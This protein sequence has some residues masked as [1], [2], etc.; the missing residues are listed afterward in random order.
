M[1][2]ES[3]QAECRDCRLPYSLH[4]ADITFSPDD[5]ARITGK[6][7]RGILL[8]GTCIACRVANLPG[9]VAIRARLDFGRPNA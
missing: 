3:A 2:D 1:N 7:D 4:G 8:C 6:D 5:W 9:A